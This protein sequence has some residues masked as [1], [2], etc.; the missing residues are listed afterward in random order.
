MS[1]YKILKK[2]VLPLC[3]R[4]LFLLDNMSDYKILKKMVLPL[5]FSFIIPL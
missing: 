5:V 1:D 3:F 2:M 4:L